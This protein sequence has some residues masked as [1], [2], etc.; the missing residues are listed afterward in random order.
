M[1]II[2]DTTP[3]LS[4]VK[5]QK[6][7]LLEQLYKEIIVPHAVYK[8]LVDNPNYRIEADEIRNAEYIV[9]K[10]VE[11]RTSVDLLMRATGLDAGESEAIIMADDLHADML[12]ID[13]AKGRSVAMQMGLSITGTIGILMDAFHHELLSKEDILTCIT[14]LKNNRRFISDALYNYLINEIN[15]K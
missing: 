13:E 14:L 8:E 7:E 12:I 6:L 1:I 2:S 10:A 11:N 15:Q 4:L 3:I 9:P 5:I